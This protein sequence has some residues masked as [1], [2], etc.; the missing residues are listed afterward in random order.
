VLRVRL[1]LY[2]YVLNKN[3]VNAEA[4]EI[5][6]I[7]IAKGIIEANADKQRAA[8]DLHTRSWFFFFRSNGKQQ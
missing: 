4:Q 5:A 7:N 3:Q 6:L 1:R 2:L 8:P